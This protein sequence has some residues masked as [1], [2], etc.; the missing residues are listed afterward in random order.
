MVDE[1]LSKITETI[2]DDDDKKETLNESKNKSTTTEQPNEIKDSNYLDSNEE[3]LQEMIDNSTKRVSAKA[4]VPDLNHDRL[5]ELI[6]G[7]LDDGDLIRLEHVVIAGQGNRLLNIKSDNKQVQDFL[8]L[9]PH[10]MEKIKKIHESIVKGDF[11]QIQK[12]L[13]RKRFA[14]CRDQYGNSPLH[15]AVLHGHI[16]I[17]LYIITQFPETIDGPDNDGRT[18]FHYSA[19][20]PDKHIYQIL[21]TAGANKKQNDRYGFTPVDY[22]TNGKLTIRDLLI[23]YSSDNNDKKNEADLW[24]RPPT[25]EIVSQLTPESG[26][27]PSSADGDDTKQQ[28][29]SSTSIDMNE[30]KLSMSEQSTMIINDNLNGKEVQV[31]QIEPRQMF[32]N[33]EN[34]QGNHETESQT[35][36]N[37]N[38]LGLESNKLDNTV[39]DNNNNNNNV[40][41]TIIES[42]DNNTK[43]ILKRMETFD[44]N[45]NNN[46]SKISNESKSPMVDDHIF[47]TLKHE[48]NQTLQNEKLRLRESI[49]Q[50]IENSD[51]IKKGQNGSVIDSIQNAQTTKLKISSNGLSTFGYDL[52]QIKDE[53]GRT[54][55]HLAAAKD[56]K[57]NI[58]YKMLQ[59]AKYLVPELDSKYRT[60]REI[61]VQNGIKN[62]LQIIDQFIIDCFLNEDSD[63]LK[64]LLLEGYS[65]L[66]TVVDSEGNDIISL[67]NRN[68]IVSMQTFVHEAAELQ[69]MRDE[70]H[71]FIRNGYLEGVVG[72]VDINAQLVIAKSNHGRTSLHLAV[73]F[74]NLDIIEILIK[75]NHQVI[76]MPDNL[77]RTPLHYAMAMSKMEE[78]GRILIHSGA[79]KVIR[80]VRMRI[81]S[82]Y[83][84]YKQEI[85]DIKRE[86]QNLAI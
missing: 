49:D 2:N 3:K 15:L 34:V 74:G 4:N 72:L 29:P 12:T 53:H 79:E 38:D 64:L 62:N 56:Q 59:Q 46:D 77:G 28:R 39:S 44:T 57:R 71:T 43:P 84:V 63:Y 70:L 36:I 9:V 24:E 83:F 13:T 22:L 17:L 73:L 35:I 41:N 51:V 19:V 45:N 66:L 14:L 23:K 75:A 5:N 21:E 50:E 20:L 31:L 52:T 18:P 10:Y 40:D 80:D 7:W 32:D 68:N 60:I 37:G 26:S 86:E 1:N 55:L 61:A 16:D 54:V 6:N 69:R 82:Y 33:D 47:E 67:L 81:P 85:R 27:V 48:F 76:N 58:F 42:T 11:V 65:T 8:N 30:Q 25:S 78:M